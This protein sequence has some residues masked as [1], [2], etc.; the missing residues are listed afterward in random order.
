MV[1][2]VDGFARHV[3]ERVVHPSH[4]PLVGKAEAALFGGAADARP[5]GGFLGQRDGPGQRSVTTA[6]R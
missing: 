6:L 3:M 4:V 2:A 5:C 1:P